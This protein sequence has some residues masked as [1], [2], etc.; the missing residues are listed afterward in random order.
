MAPPSLSSQSQQ[1]KKK[2]KKNLIISTINSIP[3]ACKSGLLLCFSPDNNRV[4]YYFVSP[5]HLLGMLRK[6]LLPWK[7]AQIF[8]T[9]QMLARVMGITLERLLCCLLS[10]TFPIRNYF[11]VT[12]KNLVTCHLI[13]L[14]VVFAHHQQKNVRKILH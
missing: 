2:K 3:V 1:I 10:Y 11:N 13:R 9:P 14:K 5:G 8:N 4:P 7:R 12:G 6:R